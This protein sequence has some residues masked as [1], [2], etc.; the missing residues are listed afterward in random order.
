MREEN[1]TLFPSFLPETEIS[2]ERNFWSTGKSIQ[3][4]T[5]SSIFTS[6]W[7]VAVEKNN[8]RDISI[9]ALAGRLSYFQNQW[10]N[11]LQ[12]NKNINTKLLI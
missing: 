4:Y 1:F 8:H 7:L 6:L 10:R 12:K 5:R 11:G 2:L 9:T 3:N